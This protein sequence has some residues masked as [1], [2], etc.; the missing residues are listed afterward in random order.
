[1]HQQLR[2][3]HERVVTEYEELLQSYNA[4]R[5]ANKVSSFGSNAVMLPVARYIYP[6]HAT[7]YIFFFYLNHLL[8]VF[9]SSAFTYYFE[10]SFG[11]NILYIGRKQLNIL[12]MLVLETCSNAKAS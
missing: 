2:E 9:R 8:G 4:T 3:E 1:M 7:G 12:L 5:N 11:L 10:A 6:A